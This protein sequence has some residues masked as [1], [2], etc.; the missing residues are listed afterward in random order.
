MNEFLTLLDPDQKKA[1]ESV[2]GLLVVRAGAG[3]GKTRCLASRAAV[4]LSRNAIPSSVVACTF[5]REASAS[6]REQIIATGASGVNEMRFGTLHSLAAS[7]LRKNHTL[8]GLKKGWTILSDDESENILKEVIDIVSPE[9]DKRLRMSQ[10]GKFRRVREEIARLKEN[11]IGIHEAASNLASQHR[12]ITPVIFEAYKEYEISKYRMNSLDF[13]DLAIR[14][15][16]AMRKNPET[17]YQFNICHLLVDEWQDTN[18]AQLDLVNMFVDAGSTLSVVGDD[19]QSLYAFRG[20]LPHLME[21][22][23]SLFPKLSSVA[24][25]EVVTLQTNRRSASSILDLACV[26]AN[27]NPRSQKKTLIGHIGVPGVIE[28]KAFVSD[29]AEGQW[30]AGEV[31]KIVAGGTP[32]GQVA[33]LSRNRIT[34]KNVE[35]ALISDNIPHLWRGNC[36]LIRRSVSADVMSYLKLAINPHLD[37]AFRRIAGRPSRGLGP[38]SVLSISQYMADTDST[39]YEALSWFIEAEGT[40]ARAQAGARSLATHIAWLENAV[41]EDLPPRE[42]VEYVISS[43]GVNYKEWIRSRKGKGEGDDSLVVLADFCDLISMQDDL[44][45]FLIMAELSANADE[46]SENGRVHMGTLHGCKG[47]EWDHVFITGMEANNFPSPNASK[48][49]RRWSPFDT[50]DSSTVFEERRLLHVGITRA[51]KGI[52]LSYTRG[53]RPFGKMVMSPES[54][55]FKECG[56]H[57]PELPPVNRASDQSPSVE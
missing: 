19:D 54:S 21:E 55:F 6:L 38:S 47:L 1:A 3:C 23:P 20:A 35:K 53:R 36:S 46:D 13:G 11:G 31:K 51:R 18:K 40:S 32:H 44:Q 42:I 56:L 8:A 15:V 4:I 50:R 9:E 29:R 57:L 43:K 14:A 24:G 34:L 37:I 28:A 52:V 45:E 25:V 48:H 7:Y 22:T 17:V 30:I 26:V 2:A 16:R 12:T 5:T 39:L 27:Q 33:I 49:L 41:S 10:H